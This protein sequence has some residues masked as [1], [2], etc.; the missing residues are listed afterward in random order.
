[1]VGKSGLF[2]ISKQPSYVSSKSEMGMLSHIKYIGWLVIRFYFSADST[3]RLL[4]LIS[5]QLL[6]SLERDGRAITRF[7]YSKQRA[8][9]ERKICDYCNAAT[10]QALA[11]KR[12]SFAVAAF[13]ARVEL[14][15]I[16]SLFWFYYCQKFVSL[17]IDWILI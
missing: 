11:R 16:W 9:E 5:G 17:K 10:R 3:T 1:M 13:G 2:F 12:K 6:I 8:W 4:R 7:L 15:I 14:K